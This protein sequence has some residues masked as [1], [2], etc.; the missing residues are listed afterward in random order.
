M[1]TNAALTTRL[2]LPSGKARGTLVGL[3]A[4][5]GTVASY[6][7]LLVTTYR[8]LYAALFRADGEDACRIAAVIGFGVA[9]PFTAVLALIRAGELRERKPIAAR[10]YLVWGALVLTTAAV[11]FVYGLLWLR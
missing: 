2:A 11:A 4:A 6:A 9:I 8:H 3:F 1:E 7:A 5:I 10:G